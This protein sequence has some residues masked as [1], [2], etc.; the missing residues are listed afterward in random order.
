MQSLSA[1]S[2][3]PAAVNWL[4]TSRQP[5]ILH[6]FDSAFNLI[7]ERRDVISIVTPQ[8]GSGPFN[9]VIEDDFLFSGHVNADSPISI[10]SNQLQLGDLTIRTEDAKLWSPRP[11]WESLR[12]VKNNILNKQTLSSIQPAL[13]AS[14]LNTFTIAVVHADIPAALSTT[15]HLAGLGPG[16]TPAGDDFILGAILAAWIIHPVDVANVIAKDVTDTASALTTSLSAAWLRSA[17]RGEAGILWHNF[18]DALISSN[19][20]QILEARDKI[21]AV[22]ETSGADALAGFIGVLMSLKEKELSV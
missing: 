4:K 2:L 16:L 21:L 11:Y 13:P 6:V 17:G 8:I 15:R 19:P 1:L 3:S 9:L 12:A 18:F 10:Q 5:R 7:S 20:V 14:L 22:G